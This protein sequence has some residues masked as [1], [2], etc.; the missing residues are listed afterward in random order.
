MERDYK[1]AVRSRSPS[2]LCGPALRTEH[3]ASG[4]PNR[5]AAPDRGAV[6]VRKDVRC[7]H[8]RHTH[9]DQPRRI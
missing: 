5:S 1:Q 7:I 9:Q 3:P 6:S 2:A 8:W 4:P